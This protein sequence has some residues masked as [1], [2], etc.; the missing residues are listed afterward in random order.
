M[1]ILVSAVH[2]LIFGC[3]FYQKLHRNPFQRIFVY[4]FLSVSLLLSFEDTSVF[5]YIYIYVHMNATEGLVGVWG[6]A[7]S[8]TRRVLAAGAA[9]LYRR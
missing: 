2:S 7:S 3:H 4:V 1:S 5:I 9:L 6:R 8:G